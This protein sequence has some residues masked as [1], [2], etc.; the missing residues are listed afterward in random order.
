MR[1]QDEIRQAGF[2][3]VEVVRVCFDGDGAVA[4]VTGVVHRYPRTVRVP[5]SVA[6][7]LIAAG[8]PVDYGVAD[9]APTGSR[10]AAG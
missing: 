6:A 4:T 8:A 2:R 5:L 10:V 7:R 9:G 1:L 3:R